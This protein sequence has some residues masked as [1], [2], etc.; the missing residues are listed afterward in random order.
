MQ[1][2]DF[3]SKAAKCRTISAVQDLVTELQDEMGKDPYIKGL[4]INNEEVEI[5]ENGCASFNFEINHE[6]SC[7]Y[8]TGIR[9]V[10]LDGDLTVGIETWQMK[11]RHGLNSASWRA[12]DDLDTEIVVR[13]NREISVLAKMAAKT[14]VEQHAELIERAGVPREMAKA[15]AEATG[16]G[17]AA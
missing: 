7:D 10:L 17:G 9:V 8:V 5:D 4:T 11:D 6:I 14:A 1:V 16:K 2:S 13:P 3:L 12:V 15:I